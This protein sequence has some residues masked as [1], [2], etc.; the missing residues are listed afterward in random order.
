MEIS[1]KRRRNKVTRI[2]KE[3][4][5]ALVCSHAFTGVNTAIVIKRYEPETCVIL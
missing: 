4:N 2:E 1:L 3:I 5:M